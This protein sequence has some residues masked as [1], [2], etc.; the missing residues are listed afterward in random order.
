MFY[1]LRGR[2]MRLPMIF[3]L[4]LAA[5]AACSGGSSTASP[6][7]ET[8]TIS[9]VYTIAN[10]ICPDLPGSALSYL[11]GL[12]ITVK[13]G[14]GAVLGTGK[15]S[16]EGVTTANPAACDLRYTIPNVPKAASYTIDSGAAGSVTYTYD[17]LKGVNWQ[18]DLKIGN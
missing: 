3:A 2:L 1:D 5:A 13:D 6:A 4:S 14:K 11:P 9:G 7:P 16:T 12:T 8:H 18:A 17:E 15:L 10:T